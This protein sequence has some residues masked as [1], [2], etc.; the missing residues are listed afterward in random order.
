MCIYTYIFMYLCK[1]SPLCEPWPCN[2][3]ANIALRRLI[4]CSESPSS[5][6]SSSP[7]ECFF[8]HPDKRFDTFR[9]NAGKELGVN[10]VRL[11]R[12]DS[13]GDAPT[14][15]LSSLPF[16]LRL[17][18]KHPHPYPFPYPYH[19]LPFSPPYPYPYPFPYPQHPLPLPFFS[20]LSSSLSLPF[21]LVPRLSGRGARG[22]LQQ[23]AHY[24]YDIVYT[25]NH[26]YIY[27]YMY[28]RYMKIDLCVYIYMC[29]DISTCI[30]VQFGL[31]L[32][33]YLDICI[34]T[35]GEG[36]IT[37]SGRPSSCVI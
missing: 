6:G 22:L 11:L 32:Y 16:C 35:Y 17:T 19:P 7:E 10:W 33:I 15:P 34:Y 20:S 24:T 18:Q 8:A 5:K 31:S 14:L 36:P 25:N 23:H 13:L 21:C 2:P 37:C 27:V 9:A 4:W 12:K 26:I 30:C 3:V 28:N 29:S 1:T